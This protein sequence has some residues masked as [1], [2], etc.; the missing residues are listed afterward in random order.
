MSKHITFDSFIRKGG[1]MMLNKHNLD[2][3]IIAGKNGYNSGLL[4]TK[5]RTVANDGR[6]LV[7]VTRP[8]K[9]DGEDFDSK[10]FPVI[11]KV[12]PKQEDD[13]ILPVN[14]CKEV[15]SII[16]K[17][18]KTKAIFKNVVIEQSGKRASFS[19][20]DLETA[21]TIHSVLID[22]QYPKYQEVMPQGK[23]KH[24]IG[25]NPKYLMEICQ[26]ADKFQTDYYNL[27]VLEFNDDG[28]IKLTTKNDDTGQ[29]FTAVVMPMTLKEDD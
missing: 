7:E 26:L 12:E 29:E 2:I 3:A 16:P 28:G 1:G 19:A 6:R 24:R 5:D 15:M 11:P 25:V 21:K 4:V 9:L 18:T 8:T 14:A 17:G 22:G 13:F 23:L 20:T 27:M 10:D